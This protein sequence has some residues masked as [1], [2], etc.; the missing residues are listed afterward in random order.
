MVVDLIFELLVVA[1]AILL[2]VFRNFSLKLSLIILLTILGGVY[3]NLILIIR[4]RLL[5]YVSMAATKY[6]II[7]STGVPQRRDRF[8]H[9]AAPNL[10]FLL[11]AALIYNWTITPDTGLRGL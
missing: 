8:K 2:L 3:S 6:A 1:L 9:R 10:R 4:L 5:R 11:T 7:G